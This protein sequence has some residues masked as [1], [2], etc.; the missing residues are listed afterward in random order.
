M[1]TRTQ[2]VLGEKGR[3]I[4]E[5]LRFGPLGA[6]SGDI[7]EMIHKEEV[8]IVVWGKV[9]DINFNLFYG[10]IISN[11]LLFIFND[12]IFVVKVILHLSL[13]YRE[14]GRDEENQP[15]LHD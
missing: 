1:A 12:N 13:C 3:R 14:G 9:R 10:H 11:T 6:K 4:R 8:N 5:S 2:N 7:I 15:K